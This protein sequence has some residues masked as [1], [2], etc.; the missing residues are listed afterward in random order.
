MDK[1]VENPPPIPYIP[2][3]R[4]MDVADEPKHKRKLRRKQIVSVA[5]DLEG[6]RELAKQITN[7]CERKLLSYRTR[8]SALQDK[9][10]LAI[11]DDLKNSPPQMASSSI[12]DGIKYP[13]RRTQP[14][15]T[16]ANL[17]PR[18]ASKTEKRKRRRERQKYR[19]SNRSGARTTP[20]P[21]TLTYI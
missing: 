18:K 21:V 7:T 19:T 13:K 12:T 5:V 16:K 4:I 1:E 17:P 3:E 11:V 9:G 14:I 10:T 8:S 20:K 6:I 15:P 2:V